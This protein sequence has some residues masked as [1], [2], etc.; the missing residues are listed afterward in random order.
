[1]NILIQNRPHTGKI[2]DVDFEFLMFLLSQVLEVQGCIAS[3]GVTLVFK[4]LFIDFLFLSSVSLVFYCLGEKECTSQ[5]MLA[6]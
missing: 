4:F 6:L 3:P 5:A 2:V 1:M